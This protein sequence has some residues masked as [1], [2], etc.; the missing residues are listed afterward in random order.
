MNQSEDKTLKSIDTML[1][2]RSICV[3]GATERLQYGGRFLQNLVE[4]G[5]KGRIYPINPKYTE[6]MGVPCYPD[7]ASLPEAPDLAGIIIPYENT[8][9][10]L[11]E[12]AARGVKAGVII[13]GQF[14]EMG[15]P[16]RKEAQKW[17]RDFAMSSGMRLCGPNC[18]GIANV[19][20]NIWP[21]A[22]WISV[23]KNTTA[24]EI[25]LVSQSGASAF[26]PFQLRAQ[27]RGIGLSHIISTGNEADLDASDFI[28]YCIRQPQVKGV[29]AYF[30]GIKD[31]GKLRRVAE[32]ALKL[33]KPIV[34]LKVGRS[35]AAQKAA[36]S[37]TASMTGSDEVIDALFKQLGI[38]RAEDWDELLET[39]ACLVKARP[40]K[41]KTVAIISS[42]GGVATQLSDKCE[43]VV[44]VPM[45]S[46]ATC[47]GLDRILQGF[48]SAL[49]PAD[50]TGRALTPDLDTILQL[51][52]DDDAFGGL[53]LGLAGPDDQARR[54]IKAAE[55]TDKPVLMVWIDSERATDGLRLLQRSRV[56]MFYRIENLVKALG[57]LISYHERRDGRGS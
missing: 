12:C 45:P 1:R 30:E 28:L 7:I 31:G 23:I 15:T 51:M 49:N 9:K 19:T 34:A 54:I 47:Q 17:L 24:G 25:A 14:A 20:D 33:G 26:G 3:I 52:I 27:D 42:S 39:G 44:G 21:C 46:P 2:P 6:L 10:A 37:H 41:K 55:G 50:I 11:E 22:S 36:M 57:A 5:Y 56:A 53:V 8:R 16:E 13:T 29:V 35:A 43:P 48:G 32:E 40:F 4:T 18:L 38:T